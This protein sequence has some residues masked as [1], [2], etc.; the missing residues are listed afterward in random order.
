MGVLKASPNQALLDSDT[1]NVQVRRKQKGKLKLNIEFEPKEYF[2]LA[3]E[4]L[5]SNKDKHKR[6]NKEK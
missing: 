3:N 4:Y 5:G 1:K 2:D 6:F